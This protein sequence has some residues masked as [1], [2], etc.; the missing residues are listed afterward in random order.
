MCRRKGLVE[1]VHSGV[2]LA[3][4]ARTC[5][6]SRNKAY[7]WLARFDEGGEAALE[8]R[9]RARK[10]IP[11]FEGPLA[12]R[13]LD[14]RRRLRWGAR[15]LRDHLRNSGIEDV[16]AR[17]TIENLLKRHGL[18]QPRQRRQTHVPFRYAGPVPT[19]PN[20]RWTM[21]FK[22]DFRLG[23]GTK[24]LPFTLRDAASRKILSIRVVPSTHTDPTKAELEHVFRDCGLPKELQSDN[25]PPFASSG[26][27]SLSKLSVWLLKLGVVPVFSRP[28]KP[29][30]NGGHERMHR[31]L[32]AETTRPPG[33]DAI[34]QQTKFNAFRSCFNAERPHEALSGDVPDQHWEPSPRS[35][36]TGVAA[37]EYPGWWETRRVCQSDGHFSWRD[38]MIS[39]TV[40][41]GGEQI[42]L[43]PV[44]D[45][46]WRIHFYSFAIGLF[47]ERP[48]RPVV[49]SIP[50]DGGR[51]A[52]KPPGAI[53]SCT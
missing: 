44:D 42:G 51:P 39:L 43:E 30:D 48:T 16:P 33:Y 15:K 19:E 7:K 20:A 24:C 47:D 32:K 3:E 9:S 14:T 13:V 12:E 25:G 40:A 6:M 21:D 53:P 34:A 35:F 10:D 31:D 2:G 50:R 36:P 1:L 28:G 38:E 5:G 4:A 17:S 8:D 45:G 37:P 11:R 52:G 46:L 41:L 26:L 29:Q 22:G 27:S 23:N 18:V 49:F